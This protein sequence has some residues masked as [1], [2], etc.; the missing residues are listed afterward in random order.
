MTRLRDVTSMFLA[1]GGIGAIAAIVLFD[2]VFL[3]L[4]PAEYKT[5]AGLAA[6]GLAGMMLRGPM[7]LLVHN[8]RMEDRRGPLVGAVLIGTVVSYLQFFV[9]AKTA[10]ASS[11]AWCIYLYPA[12]TCTIALSALRNPACVSSRLATS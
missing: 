1:I 8:L 5:T 4:A 10:G 6:I 2:P 3:A 11:A 12:I 7:A 9:L